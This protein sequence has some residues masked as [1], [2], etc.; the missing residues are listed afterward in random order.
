MT[1]VPVTRVT[2]F[3]R[4]HTEDRPCRLGNHRLS[5]YVPDAG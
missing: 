3:L 4:I 2:D 1:E 5:L